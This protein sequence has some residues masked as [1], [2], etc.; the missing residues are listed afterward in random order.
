MEGW[1]PELDISGQSVPYLWKKDG[2][3]VWGD[4][5]WTRRGRVPYFNFSNSTGELRVILSRRKKVQSAYRE[6][7][8]KRLIGSCVWMRRL[9]WP[10]LTAYGSF[11]HTN[12]CNQMVTK[13]FVL[14][15]LMQLTSPM[16]RQSNRSSD[17]VN[18]YGG[19]R[20][21][22]EVNQTNGKISPSRTNRHILLEKYRCVYLCT[23]L[24]CTPSHTPPE[25]T[26]TFLLEICIGVY[27]FVLTLPVHQ[28]VR[29]IY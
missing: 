10:W 4:F 15:S 23:H 22:G 21:D 25:H 28:V 29:S 3:W 14:H 12:G 8:T 11:L 7:E 26:D 16:C 9:W 17:R 19:P 13:W 20:R 24:T 1:T 2:V 6:W 5:Q 27:I 18:I